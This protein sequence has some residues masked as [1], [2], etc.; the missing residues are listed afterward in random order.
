MKRFFG[1][2]LLAIGI[3]I[4][5]GSGLCT[6]IFDIMALSETRSS[7][8]LSFIVLSLFVGGIPFVVGLGLIFWGRWL[9][10]RA[11]AESAVSERDLGDIYR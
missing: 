9:L 7:E 8:G 6:I 5:G 11:R 2:V 10:R 4:A 1:G 3:L